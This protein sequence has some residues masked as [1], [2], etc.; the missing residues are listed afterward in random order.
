MSV[1]DRVSRHHADGLHRIATVG[2]LIVGALLLAGAYG[3]F[4]AVWDRL[5]GAATPRIALAA[6]GVLLLTSGV[7]N[8]SL[9]VWIWRATQW[10]E[11]TA[12]AANAMAAGYFVYL[13]TITVPDHPIGL[14]LVTVGAQ[15]IVLTTI[16]LGM[17]WPHP[18]LLEQS[19]R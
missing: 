18:S 13:L 16:C 6:P 8:L 10:A 12:L 1:S 19:D 3:H 7:I 4:V 5:T 9:S 11:R 17:R 14:F 15:A 2:C